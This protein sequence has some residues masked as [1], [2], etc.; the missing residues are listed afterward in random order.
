MASIDALLPV[1][2]IDKDLAV[3]WFCKACTNDLRVAASPK[4]VFFFNNAVS[5]NYDSL[6]PIIRAMVKSP[7]DEVAQEGAEEVTAR[8]LFHG[9]FE[10]DLARCQNGNLPQRKGVAQIVSHFLSDT[11]YAAQC[12]DLIGPLINDPEKDV[13]NETTNLFHSRAYSSEVLDVEFVKSFVRSKTFA[14]HPYSFV[15][16]LKNFPGSLVPLADVVFTVCEV[17]S[18]T[19]REKSR[20][21]G[22]DV[23][24]TVSEACTLLLRLYEQSHNSNYAEIT[25][26][27]LDA[28]DELFQ[29]R[30]G[31]VREISKT[32]ER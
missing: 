28:W 1:L 18:T 21:I 25:N 3:E 20:E 10:Q 12:K 7:I 8:W 17:F 31:I 5:S 4:A 2:N 16:W 13:R 27:C 9:F 14:D 29:N 30:V 32:I 22:T 11:K 23:P 19:L 24:Y 15:D 6:G 26:R